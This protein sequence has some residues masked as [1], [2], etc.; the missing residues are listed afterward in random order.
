MD[1]KVSRRDFLKS[2][3]FAASATALQGSGLLALNTLTPSEAK[4]A[5]LGMGTYQVRY[6]ADVMC[7]AECG[8]E[9]W[10]QNGRVAKI[11]GNKAV[12]M[13]DGACCAK[14][15]SGQQLI[16]SPYRLKHPLIRV[17]KRGEGKFRQASWDE[18]IDV[19]AKKLTDIKKKYGAEAV[20]MDCGDVTDRDQYHRLFFAYGTPNCVEHGAICDTPRRHGPKLMVNGKRWEPDLMRPQLVRQPDGSLKRDYTYRTK[21]IVYN[22]WNPFVAT[23]IAYE[24]RGTVAAQ[25]ESDCKVIV[26][27]PALSNTA[28]KADLW[29]APRAGTDGD[30]FGAMLRYILENDNQNDPARKY[31]DWNFKKYSVGWDE[32][33]MAFK[34]WCTK[35]DPINGL[36]YCSLD[37]AANRTGLDKAQIQ[38][39]AHLFGITKPAALVWGMQSPGHHF[40]GYCA[41]IIGVALNVITG[42]FEVPGGGIDTEI[43][44]SSKGGSATGKQF[45]KRKVH[46]TIAGKEIE[47]EVESL[48]MDAFGSKFP[49]AWDDVVADYPDAIENGVEIRYGPF[50]GLRYPMK[51]YVLRT[52]NSVYTGSAPYA[53]QKAITAKDASGN[54]KLELMVVIDTLYLESALYADVILPEASYAERQSVADIYPSH[55]L[56]YNRDAVIEPLYE[57]K[58]PTEIMNLIAKRLADLGDSDLKGSDFWQKYRTEEDFVNEMLAP[59]PGKSNIG[60]PLPYPKYPEGYT[61]IGTP[62]SLEHGDVTIDHEKK[63]VVGKLLT[64]EWLRANNGVAVWPMSWYRYKKSNADE[65]NGVF[66]PT[67]TKKIEFRFDWTEGGK[68]FGGYRSYNEKIEKASGEAPEGLKRIGF[69]KYPPTF[70]WFETVWNPHTNP[71]YA[72]YGK[73]YPFQLISGKVHHAMSG[74]QMVPWLGELKT[75]GTW[76]PLNNAFECELPEGQAVGREPIKVVKKNIKAN[77]YSVGTVWMNSG[78][79]S[80]L[81]LKTGDLVVVSNPLK[82]SI[83]GKVFASGGMRP[84]VIKMGFG[85]GGRFSPGLGPA[86]QSRSYTP[87][88]NE[89]V[90]PTALSPIMG[91]PAYADMIVAV[92]KA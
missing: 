21:L 52:G 61:L 40:N 30:L 37:W 62:D 67:S 43:V 16:Y 11:Y 20:V 72:K 85:T 56:I 33:E 73:D 42:N 15:S 29:L 44:K 69:K 79:A 58:K 68:R 80:R 77:S 71:E 8:M 10:V 35:S 49:A 88:H 31:I 81:G 87:L 45:L 36:P 5:Q 60:T 91:F 38:E 14:G 47:G 24:S 39:V 66:P 22:G 48:H 41:S 9:M 23:R 25:H 76:Q 75:E 7:P 12:A 74:T 50:R 46:R 26:V 27:D 34:S 53:W 3:G 6:T 57:S 1:L 92:R 55:P 59:A 84:G 2:A 18:A 83:R 86:Y 19:L 17:G 90:D 70:F 4:A 65:P 54:Y 82:R 64:A 78:D 13:N 63:T 32:F 28:A 89:M 51:A